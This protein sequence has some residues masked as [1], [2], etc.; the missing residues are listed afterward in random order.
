VICDVGCKLPAFRFRW[1]AHLDHE[2]ADQP[3]DLAA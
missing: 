2:L 1:L 3:I